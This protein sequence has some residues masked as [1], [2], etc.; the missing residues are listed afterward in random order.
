MF[1]AA[2]LSGTSSAQEATTSTVAAAPSPAASSAYPD[3]PPFDAEMGGH[4]GANGMK[5]AL[6]TGD[7]AD[8]VKAAALGAVPGG[9]VD[10]VENDAEGSPYEAHMTKPDGSRVTVKVDAGFKATKVETCPNHH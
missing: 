6:L 1:G 2:L 3:R 7:I 9:T 4:V 8:K 10:R 5:E